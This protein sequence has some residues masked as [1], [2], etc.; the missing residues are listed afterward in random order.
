MILVYYKVKNS[1]NSWHYD[2]YLIVTNNSKPTLEE[3]IKCRA[4]ITKQWGV[5]P[6][7]I[8]MMELG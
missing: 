7:I 3:L 1:Y 5:V 8:N 6:V 2:N 4:N